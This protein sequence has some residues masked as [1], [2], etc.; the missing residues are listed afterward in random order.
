MQKADLQ[1]GMGDAVQATYIEIKQE[2]DERVAAA[3]ARQ[4][5]AEGEATRLMAWAKET[6]VINLESALAKSE[7]ELKK[8]RARVAALEEEVQ[9]AD[10]Q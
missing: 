5:A 3:K 9:R 6:N 8:S 2:A 1:S 7:S 4:Q 10:D